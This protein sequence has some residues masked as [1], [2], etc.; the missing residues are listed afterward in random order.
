MNIDLVRQ[1]I[2]SNLNKKVMVSVYGLRNKVSRYE[3][4]LY[5]TYPNIFSIISDGVE[6]SFSYNEYIT[7]DVKI[8]FL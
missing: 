6:K 8:K 3:G 7:G 1:K 2:E 5:K 4:I